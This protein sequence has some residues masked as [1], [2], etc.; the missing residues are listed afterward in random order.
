MSMRVS[1][2]FLISGFTVGCSVTKEGFSFSSLDDNGA[3]VI[4]SLNT[5]VASLVA[6][7][8]SFFVFRYWRAS[9]FAAVSYTVPIPEQCNGD[10]EGKVLE[11]PSIKVRI[12]ASGYSAIPNLE[13]QSESDYM[14]QCYCPAN[15]RLLG[16]VA[17]VYPEDIDQA[18]ARSAA[19]QEQWAK[20]SFDERR[21]VLRSLL[22]YVPTS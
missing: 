4:P 19:A 1:F 17:P 14:I 15:G 16:K 21:R 7:V 11:E 2:D 22:K 20:T 13:V 8:L 6:V 10:W 18:I 5:L 9:R 3:I 12:L